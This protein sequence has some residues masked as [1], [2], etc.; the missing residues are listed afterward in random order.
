MSE[1]SQ[2]VVIL[3][4]HFPHYGHS[5]KQI[6][7]LAMQVVSEIQ[8]F[9]VGLFLTHLAHFYAALWGFQHYTHK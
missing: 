4:K 6:K 9:K 7:M 8:G 2:N 5:I 3:T 1:I